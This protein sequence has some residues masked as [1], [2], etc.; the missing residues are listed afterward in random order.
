ML[1]IDLIAEDTLDE[2]IHKRN[3]MKST[4]AAVV[5]DGKN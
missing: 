1:Y 5:I 2:N 3:T 4:I